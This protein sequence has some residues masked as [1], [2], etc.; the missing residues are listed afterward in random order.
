MS[1]TYAVSLYAARAASASALAARL[2]VTLGAGGLLPL[3]LGLA[4]GQVIGI[5]LCLFVVAA[6][7]T[8]V[9]V[10]QQQQKTH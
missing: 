10:V 9:L 5:L 8:A 3:E 7:A 4:L 2:K 1:F 6:A